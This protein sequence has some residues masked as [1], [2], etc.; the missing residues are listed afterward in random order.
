MLHAL[1]ACCS[2]A[3]TVFLLIYSISF[4]H[5]CY[6]Y[7][8][9]KDAYNVLRLA[10]WHTEKALISAMVLSLLT[11][12]WAAVT[13]RR[14]I[15]QA[16]Q[17]GIFCVYKSY[18]DYIMALKATRPAN[19]DTPCT[20][21]SSTLAASLTLDLQP[22]DVRNVLQRPYQTLS[23]TDAHVHGAPVM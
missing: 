23:T 21:C 17:A 9:N 13:P 4:L 20:C 5:L 8:V 15:A 14:Q 12:Q 10:L 16:S 1:I 2:F 11:R 7:L 6:H 3:Y 22:S 19:Y 18:V